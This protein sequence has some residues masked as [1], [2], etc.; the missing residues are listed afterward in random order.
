[1]TPDVT[2]GLHLFTIP[3]GANFAQNL[4]SGLIARTEGGPL[5]LSRA[6]I[7]LPTRRAARGFG[8]TFARVMGGSALL[9]QFRALGFAGGD[10]GDDDFAFDTVS[11]DLDLPPAIDPIRRRLLLASLIRRWD[12]QQRGGSLNA[13]QALHLAESL[14]KLMDELE[15]QGSDLGDLHHLAPLA[16][17]EHWREVTGFLDLIQT[18]WPAILQAEGRINPAARQNAAMD[19][20]IEKLARDQP[21]GMVIA[22]GSTGSIPATARLLKAIAQLEKGAVVLPGL[23]P[24]L[25][26][27]SWDDL[28]PGH[29]QFGMKQL[30]DQMG[31]SRADVA[32]WS[33]KDSNPARVRLLREAL[34]PAP[35][36]DAWRAIAEQG[37]EEI[38]QGLGGISLIEANDPAEEAL[39]I[40][41]ALRHTL[42]QEGR[43]AALVTPDRNLAR[44]V[45]AELTRWDIA[46]DDSAGRPLAHTA[47]GAFLLLL[48]DAARAR[49]APVPLLALLKHPFATLGGEPGPFR[50]QVRLL[51]K[52][53]LRG[54]RPDPGLHGIR[55][56]IA[57]AQSDKRKPA[58]HLSDLFVWWK[59]IAAILAPLE[60]AFDKKTLPMAELVRIHLGVAERLSCNQAA[61]CPLW[62]GPDGEAA[63]ILA[64]ELLESAQD[65]PETETDAYPALLRSLMM[66]VAVRPPFT[67]RSIVILGPLEARLQRFDLTIL[68]GLNEGNWPAAPPADPWFSRPMRA[69]LGLEQPERRI[70]LAAHDFASLAAGPEVLLTRSL[71]ADG[72]PAIASRW[73][74][75]LTQLLR[76]LE[77]SERLSPPVDYR[78]LA[79]A[80]L[81]VPAAPRIMRPAPA[82]PVATRPRR[83][84]VTEIE[85]WLR[86][87]YAIYAKHILKLQKLDALDE[88]AGP[89]ER[90]NVFH[91]ALELFVK[92]H[93]GPISEDALEMLSLIAE[94][95]F[96]EMQIPAAQ[97]AVWRPRFLSAASWFLALERTR[98]DAIAV[99]H[100]E[101]PGRMTLEGPAGPFLLTG[102][103]DRIDLLKNGGAAIL[104]YKTGSLPEKNWMMRFLTPQLPLEAAMLA[105]GGFDGLPALHASE[106]T[107]LRLSGGARGGEERNFPGT[108]G[109]EAQDRLIQRIAWFDDAVAPYPSR[110]APH[111]ARSEGDYDHLARVREWAPAGWLE[112]I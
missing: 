77:L 88:E 76:G 65:L 70:G 107:Y 97:R 42:E 102:K 2:T 60:Q 69:K 62:R 24:G 104:D 49:F 106:L 98:R 82:P 43:S 94:E 78:A 91:R 39:V 38:A 35:T 101:I 68:G 92:R 22:A 85:T 28:D 26:E 34:R 86:D 63:A 79:R 3:A 12:E 29:P 81:D 40:A 95:V 14:A 75:R 64:G 96:A 45:A 99:S 16:L 17:A 55:K 1:V 46:I 13:V 90:G 53:V 37:S 6:V 23:D 52:Y 10:D 7:Y 73:L 105:A 93:P 84:S 31:A 56:A 21:Q 51:D 59:R 8:E 74:E 61:D 5:A 112:D 25:D 100:L 30:L 111:S 27:K 87:P 58:A 32:N 109:A 80:L 4:A 15:R 41:L 44:R 50:A 19:F 57:A 48:A 20:L 54:P 33:D 108:M 67:S 110:V 11:E 83:L 89:L 9:P 18:A 47:T 66:R 72:A 103:A 36:T 71:K